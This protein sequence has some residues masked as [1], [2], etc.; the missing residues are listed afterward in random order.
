MA[1]VTGT[2]DIASLLANKQTTVAQF[3]LDNIQPILQAEIDAH[4][5]IMTQMVGE[6]ADVSGDR[7]R[8]SGTSDSGEMSEV[9]EYGRGP[10]QKPSVGASVG[11]PLRLFQ[12]GLGW[13]KKWFETHSPADMAVAVQGA[14][15]AHRKAV[16]R[17]IK[18]AIFL[19]TN[20]TFTDD[21]VAPS[22]ALPVKRFV[23]ADSAA[24][25]EGPNGESFDGST[26]THYNA[27]STSAF[28]VAAMNALISDVLEHGHGQD[29]RVYV[30]VA[31]AATVQGLSGFSPLIDPRLIMGTQANQPAMR[32]DITRADNRAIGIFGSATVWVKP[33]IPANY[34]FAFAADDPSKPLVVRTRNGGQVA[35]EIAAELDTHPLHAQ[36]M[37]SEFGAGVWTRTNGAVLY[38]A[39]TTYADP[40]IS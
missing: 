30:N 27:S 12:Y 35:L 4:N 16:V 18:R 8:L 25:P 23:N 10:T 1:T 32:L 40:T 31:D 6:L 19:S 13:T 22:A 34:A 39:S 24:I 3:G 21:L 28:D 38:H 7:L 36:Y 15:K 37:E 20:Y 14:E 9:D 33:W 17:E 2:N 5:L 29:L 26:H 11:F